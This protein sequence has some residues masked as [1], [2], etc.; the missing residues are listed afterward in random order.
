MT[1]YLKKEL[2]VGD[3]KHQCYLTSFELKKENLLFVDLFFYLDQYYKDGLIKNVDIYNQMVSVFN[4]IL[5]GFFQNP[6]KINDNSR[7]SIKI[8]LIK[9]L[10][11]RYVLVNQEYKKDIKELFHNSGFIELDDFE[12]I[13]KIGY[14]KLI[15]GLYQDIDDLGD[16]VQSE[17]E[18]HEILVK[19]FNKEDLLFQKK[20]YSTI[21]FL[22]NQIKKK[23]SQQLDFFLI[24]GSY[25]TADYIKQWSDLDTFIILNK[26]VFNKIDQLAY[27]QKEL[28]KLSLLCYKI[29]PLAHHTFFVLPEF[30]LKNYSNQFL[31]IP[32]L[33]KSVALFKKGNLSL[34]FI[35]NK[36]ANFYALRFSVN[37][38]REKVIDEK[39]SENIFKYEDDIASI[40]I[41]PTFMMQMKGK[42]IYKKF[43]FEKIKSV[44]PDFDSSFIDLASN[45]RKNWQL[46]NWLDFYPNWLFNLLPGCFNNY[47]I[48]RYR[49]YL[50]RFKKPDSL[51]VKNFT[52]KSL[53]LYE[54][55][56]KYSLENFKHE[57]K[58]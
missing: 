9:Y 30:I 6:L 8:R 23:L 17:K 28:Q 49:F 45:K 38:L 58:D 51:E 54:T 1:D 20:E 55:F 32:V 7:K 31:P 10:L 57:I 47:L 42:P 56:F 13:D 4:E 39:Y 40:L 41:L 35:D 53:D 36:L 18:K 19:D 26:E 44:F 37:R 16:M 25:A 48:N 5:K 14:L 50:M 52:K 11:L 22:Q 34:N 2:I 24:Q 43:S 27:T 33:K 29:N 46:F 3:F 15:S 21:V 12:K